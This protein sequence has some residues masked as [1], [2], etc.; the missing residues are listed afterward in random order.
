MSDELFLS[1]KTYVSSKRA[2]D[3]SGYA[4]DY[5]GQ[6][7]RGGLIDAQRVGGL[8]YVS[9]ESLSGY[10]KNADTY[11]PQPPQTGE[12]Q[13]PDAESIVSFDGKD[14]V[15]AGRAAK[16]TGYNQDYIG[17]LA[18]RGAIL[19]RQIGNRWYID[20]DA[21]VSHKT[22]KDKMLGAVQSASVGISHAIAPEIP[23]T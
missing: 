21:L 12:N 18:R 5:I 3:T 14:Y 23:A 13:V 8:W 2:A 10:K 1:G 6:L 19:S 16:I 9:M 15:S 7:A 17:Q 20:R 22:E 4:Q 11:Q